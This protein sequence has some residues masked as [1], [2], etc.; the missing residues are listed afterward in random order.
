MEGGGVTKGAFP[1]SLFA[2]RRRDERRLSH[3]AF[4]RQRLGCPPLPAKGIYRFRKPFLR[5]PRPLP[6]FR[7]RPV[8]CCVVGAR[9][10]SPERGPPRAA[11]AVLRPAP[12]GGLP[13]PHRGGGR[14]GPLRGP[15]GP[16]AP[17]R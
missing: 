5:P 4:G 3:F 1:F 15:D 9:Y 7:A 11:I 10:H 2:G 17:P 12:A 8:R 13:L 14:H 6:V 16:A